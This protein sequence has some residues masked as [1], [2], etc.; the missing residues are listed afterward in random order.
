MAVTRRKSSCRT[1]IVIIELSSADEHHDIGV[2]VDAASQRL[3]SPAPTSSPLLPS[4]PSIRADFIQGMGKIGGKFVII[5][6]IQK[7][8]SVDEIASLA[9]MAD[10]TPDQVD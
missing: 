4:A 9:T 5:L 7:V 3:K 1:C 10:R 2:V 6:D 8:L